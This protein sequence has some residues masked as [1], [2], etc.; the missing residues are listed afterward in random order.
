MRKL[1]LLLP[2]L[3]AA[4]VA[5]GPGAAGACAASDDPCL[6]DPDAT[7]VRGEVWVDR[8]N[9]GGP[10]NADDPLAGIEVF[11]DLNDDSFRNPGE[12]GTATA[13]D[14]TYELEID[15]TRTED[16]PEAPKVRIRAPYEGRCTFP[17]PCAHQRTYVRGSDAED[18]SFGVSLPAHVVGNV[19]E[20]FNEDGARQPDERGAGG[21]WMYLDVNRDGKRGHPRDEPVTMIDQ[22]GRFDLTVPMAFLGQSLHLRMQEPQGWACKQPKD[23][24]VVVGPLTSRER[25]DAGQM[26]VAKPVIVFVHGFLGSEI[27]CGSKNL[28]VD[29]PRS[30][31]SSMRLDTDGVTNLSRAKGGTE[32][33][34]NAGPNGKLV[35]TVVGADIYGHS[36]SHLRGLAAARRFHAIAWDWRKDPASQTDELDAVIDRLLCD[37]EETCEKT[38]AEKVVL[39]A[40]S[41]GGLLSRQYIADPA[42][43]RK[44]RRL[45]TVGTP[46]WG[47]PKASFPVVAGI[48]T[49]L[50]SPMDAFLDDDELKEL[51]RNLSG[52]LAL[53]PAPGYGPWLTVPQH[54]AGQM[55]ADQAAGFFKRIGVTESLVR[56]QADAHRNLYDHYGQLNGVDYEVVVGTGLPTIQEVELDYGIMDQ[57]E[58]RFGPGDHTVPERSAAFDAP[59]D[60]LHYV[61]GISHVP[62]TADLMTTHIMDRWIQ[63]GEPMKTGEDPASCPVDATEIKVFNGYLGKAFRFAAMTA[64]AAKDEP[65]I[66]VRTADRVLDLQAAENAGL[67]QTFAMGGE[68]TIV[69]SD[70]TPVQVEVE[71]GSYSL[72]TRD[73]H[74]TQAGPRRAYQ[75]LSG[76]VVVSA[77]GTPAVKRGGRALK[78]ASKA[79]R[80]PPRTTAK[81]RKLRGGKVRVTL[82][83]RDGASKVAATLLEVGGKKRTYLE[84]VTLTRKQAARARFGSVDAAGNAETSRKLRLP[85]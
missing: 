23:C 47:S 60:K 64:A 48:E 74:D 54:A 29:V 66:R 7:Y 20:D 42:R 17:D 68:T 70:T 63:N 59:A 71:G 6:Q 57:V 69:A 44:V 56:G 21:A 18:V 5:F 32:C 19:H 83:A 8:H 38:V 82:R 85:R 76:K 40:H 73:L 51:M 84:A 65:K 10:E 80:T 3:L 33:T 4:T 77:A 50:V 13:A 24:D 22:Y 2:A 61:C 55:N 41:Q 39:V 26:M 16:R 25:F 28:W 36:V 46:T 62:L 9:D 43:A 34:E 37:G 75:G 30:E 49:P 67:V 1:T 52:G 14:G 35:E 78:P 27:N 15:V 53:L 81:V 31:V 45:V 11:L 72:S 58:V 12:P 79:D